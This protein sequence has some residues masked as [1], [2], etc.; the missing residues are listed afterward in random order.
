M[1]LK[2]PGQSQ[3]GS[4]FGKVDISE[5]WSAVHFIIHQAQRGS[6]AQELQLF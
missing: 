1:C 5:D 3:A 2:V 6:V 4:I